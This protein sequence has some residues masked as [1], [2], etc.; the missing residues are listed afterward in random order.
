MVCFPGHVPDRMSSTRYLGVTRQP[1]CVRGGPQGKLPRTFPE[2]P[3]RGPFPSVRHPVPG[4]PRRHPT[5]LP[6]SCRSAHWSIGV[7]RVPSTLQWLRHV[8]SRGTRESEGGVGVGVGLDGTEAGLGPGKVE[9]RVG[10]VGRR[11]RGT[12]H[13]PFTRAKEGSANVVS[14]DASS[15]RAGSG[16]SH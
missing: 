8:I 9:G 11:G 4:V 3:V 5:G 1:W 13:G 16:V 10:R 12:G 15:G 6:H 7:N 2:S 14:L